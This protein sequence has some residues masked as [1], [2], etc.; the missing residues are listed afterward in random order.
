MSSM[1]ADGKKN[2]GFAKIG[3]FIRRH[4]A[5]EQATAFLAKL[6]RAF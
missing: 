6:D 5:D 2:Q 4:F 1:S 3:F